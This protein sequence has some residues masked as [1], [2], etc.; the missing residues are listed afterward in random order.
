MPV[1]VEQIFLPYSRDGVNADFMVAA[2]NPCSTESRFV[3]QG[4]LR[5]IAKAPL[6]WAVIIDPALTAAPRPATAA[7]DD[8]DQIVLDDEVSAATGQ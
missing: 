7:D 3:T 8:A 5:N 4:L 1:T 6:H 2:L